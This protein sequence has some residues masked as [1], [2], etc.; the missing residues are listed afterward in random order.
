MM[1]PTLIDRLVTKYEDAL[2]WIWD[3]LDAWQQG[4]K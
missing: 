1:F 4:S 3:R 2:M